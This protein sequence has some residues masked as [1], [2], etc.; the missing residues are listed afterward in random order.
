[1]NVCL[2]VDKQVGSEIGESLQVIEDLISRQ[3]FLTGNGE[4]LVDCQVV[5]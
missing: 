5:E 4:W 2:F 3:T 1:M